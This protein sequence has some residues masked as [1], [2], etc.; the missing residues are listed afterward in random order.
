MGGSGF[1]QTFAELD[2]AAN[3]LSRLLRSAGLEPGD[4]VAICMENHDRY[5]EVVWGCHYAGLVYTC[6]SSRLQSGELEYII[7]DC[8][9]QVFITSK[10]KADQAAEIVRQH[11]GGRAAADARRHDRRLRELRGRRRRAVG[12]AA[13]APDRRHRHAV[14]VRHDRPTQGRGAPVQGDADGRSGVRRAR[15]EPDAVR[16]RR[17][18]DLPLPGAVLPRRSAALLP[19]HAGPRQHRG[20]DGA[21][22]RRGVPAPRR[23]LP[24]HAQP[25]RAD[26]VHPHAQAARRRAREVR[27]V[28]AG[29]RDPRRRSVPGAGQE[30]D[31]RVVRPG[32]PR[33]LRR[34][35]GQRLRL[36][37]QRDV[38][39]PRGHGRHADRMHRA[40]RRRGRRGSPARRVGHGVLRGRRDASS[41]TTTRRRRRARATPRDGRRSATSATST[42]TTSCTSPTARRT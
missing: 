32:D 8:E 10:Y 14:L 15:A 27:R 19:R 28:V 18:E 36:L 26:D 1:T 30:A 4:H 3:R 2:A 6:T 29:V 38:A 17:H 16:R 20:G 13:R 42:P 24:R 41:T 23:A 12:R 9:A 25:G 5:L 33:V 22:R 35:R 40:H 31:D 37:Q 7:N 11:A 39:R 21:L 34:H